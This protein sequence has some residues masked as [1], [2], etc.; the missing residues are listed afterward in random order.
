ML[1]WVNGFLISTVGEY[2]P[3]REIRRCLKENDPELLG[4]KGDDFERTYFKKYGF[5]E[6]GYGRTYETTVF[7]A[8]ECECGCEGYTPSCSEF[9]DFKGYNSS[10]DATQGHYKLCE[11]WDKAASPVSIKNC[12]DWHN[13]IQPIMKLRDTGVIEED[14][15]ERLVSKL[16]Y[17]L[18]KGDYE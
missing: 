16:E 10:K 18:L 8:K 6:I 14:E 7:I 9:L 15:Y 12:P 11:V 4:L 2:L 17:K 5:E 1:T 13:N 3:D